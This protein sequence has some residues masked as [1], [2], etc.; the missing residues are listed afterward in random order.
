MSKDESQYLKSLL[1]SHPLRGQLVRR[2]FSSW[3]IPPGSRGLDL[4]CGPGLYTMMLAETPGISVHVTG[5]DASGEFLEKARC[6]A[7][8]TGMG[9]RVAFQEGD[10]RSLPFEDKSFDWA[11]SMDCVGC[12][13][14]DPVIL[15][16][17]LKRVVRPGGLIMIL[18][19]SSQVLLPGYPLLEAKLNAT[20]AGT[21]PFSLTMK[22]GRH[23]M[24]G[25][26]WLAQAGLQPA[27]ARTYVQDV[28][29]PLS[30]EMKTA[31]VDLFSMRW[32]SAEEELSPADWREYQRLCSAESPDLIIDNPGYY[33]FFT[34][35]TFQGR[36]Q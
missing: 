11:F 6:L 8:Q 32:G 22:P 3:Q 12:I 21:A 16:S 20:A 34:Y 10:A 13:P 35:S 4:G 17:E 25:L 7:G 29:A 24:C 15:L 33:A 23:T 5:V 26:E 18:I 9:D 36:V 28:C 14:E 2:I 30:P 19:W 27:R 31:L 1:L